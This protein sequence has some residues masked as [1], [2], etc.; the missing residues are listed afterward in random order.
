MRPPVDFR[1]RHIRRVV[2]EKQRLITQTIFYD[3]PYPAFQPGNGDKYRSD[4]V[5]IR[6]Q[7]P[8][9]PSPLRRINTIC[10]NGAADYQYDDCS[11]VTVGRRICTHLLQANYV[12][13]IGSRI[14]Y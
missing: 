11:D 5:L 4:I 14:W 7:E 12:A 9:F 2:I 3:G 10:F 8:V 1:E 6:L 13:V